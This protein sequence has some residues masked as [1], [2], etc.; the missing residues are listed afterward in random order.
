MN[1]RFTVVLAFASIFPFSCVVDSDLPTPV[2]EPQVVVNGIL[3]PDSLIKVTLS[4]T[5]PLD[6]DGSFGVIENAMIRLFENDILIDT[7]KHKTNGCYFSAFKPKET[8]RYKITV[9]G[10]DVQ[11][12]IEAEDTVPIRPQYSV[13]FKKTESNRFTTEFDATVHLEFLDLKSDKFHPWV[14]FISYDYNYDYRGNDTTML[15]LQK[16]YVVNSNS[17]YLDN[18]NSTFDSYSGYSDYKFY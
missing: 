10:S 7:L 3:N 6:S 8:Y 16:F 15:I 17:P 18:F 9:S 12:D 4:R 11:A 1:L 2:G 13:C 5:L 14:E